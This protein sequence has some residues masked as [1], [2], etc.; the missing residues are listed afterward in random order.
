MNLPEYL[1]NGEIARLFPVIS[2]T[3]NEQRA[4]SIL[5]AVISAVPPLA[6][7]LF[8]QVGQQLSARTSVNT[9]TEV[10][11]KNESAANTGNRPD[12]L[13]CLETGKR[14]WAALIEA[15][16]GKSKLDQEQMERYLTLAKE[17]EVNALI[18][19]SNEFAVL[20][21]HHPVSVRKSLT[22]KVA[23]YHFSWKSILTTAMLLREQGAIADREQA[24]LIRELVRF[25]SHKSAGVTGFTSMPHEWSEAV[26][27]I[28]AGGG[29]LRREKG[30][31][32]VGAW[33]QEIRDLSL[34]MSRILGRAVDLARIIHA[35]RPI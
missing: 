11:F 34:R 27:I 29:I 31:P 8:S 4:V 35:W 9:Y 1:K 12:G 16:I 32:I 22:R 15:K 5:L 26:E 2:E 25:L 24:F 14:K 18:T 3:G 13:V 20:P 19:V 28:Q 7:R 23:L 33:H 6:D 21:T 10:V 17:N 30:T